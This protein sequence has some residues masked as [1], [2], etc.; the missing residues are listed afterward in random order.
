MKKIVAIVLAM[1]LV[2]SVTVVVAD[3][4][5][6]MQTCSKKVKV[7][8][9]FV[10]RPNQ[11]DENM[12]R[13][14]GGNTKY[15]Y[16]I[17]DAK[18]VELPEQ[19]IEHIKKNPRVKY[20]EEDA[21]VHALD[22]ELDSS[23]GVKHIGAGAVHPNNKGTGVKVAI[24]DTGIDYTHPDLIDNYAGGYDF[25]NNDP[26]P[27]DDNGHG[28]HCAGIV[29]AE[30]NEI[31]V[32]GVAPEAVLYAVKVLDSS[33]SGYF[34][35]IIAGIQWAIENDMQ[36]ISMSLGAD[37]GSASLE[38]ACNNA[39]TSGI[40]VVAAAGNDYTRR[41]RWESDTVDYPARYDSVIAVGAT[42]QADERASFSS[43]GH[44]VELA[45]PGVNIYS[46]VPGEYDTK[47]GTSMAC[48]HVAG[49]AALV[50]ASGITDNT[51]VRVR[52]QQT[53]DDLGATGLDTWYGYGLVDAEEAALP[54]TTPPDTT[55]PEQV[56]GLTVTPISSSQ[57]DLLWTASTASDLD[58]YNVYRSATSGDPYDL[59]ASPSTNSYSDTGLSASTT[60]YYTVA[61]V[62]TAGNIGER[63]AEAS[64]TTSEATAQSMHVQ[65]LIMDTGS[66]TAGKN[67]FV[68][69]VATVTIF[70][71][72]G[73][74]VEGATVYGTWSG[75]TTDSDS[76]VTNA[77]GEV[78]LTSNS[79]KNPGVVT[80]T[81]TVVNVVKDG[82][83]YD[84]SAN[85]E[86][87]NSISWP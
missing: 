80:F 75:A 81:F 12:I 17:I 15:T 7:I 13:G 73:N 36:V 8:I 46:T 82:W 66:R 84:S 29:A 61:A 53:A 2:M 41:G 50:I 79:I 28:T 56:T 22:T 1:L 72:S 34:T 11:D 42:D 68:W 70:D 9:G 18:A 51:D 57:L 40:V 65:S 83:T 78:S 26:Y 4:A 31:G 33:G 74:A 16:H 86:T 67:E 27:L 87:S 37:I 45:A 39:Y 64:G 21:E 43:T 32:V 69:A 76:G 47:S 38:E 24:I 14:L 49:T 30:D 63:S 71:A 59:V 55:P 20:V 3:N 6:D 58:H 62:D 5:N 44:D 25:V 35:D 23:W 10:D 48:P 60:Y 85:K 77:N 54:G 19:A 52:L